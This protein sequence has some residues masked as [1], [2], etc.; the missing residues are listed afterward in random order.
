MVP[1]WFW[2]SFTSLPCVFCTLGQGNVKA[3]EAADAMLDA[4]IGVLSQNT[5]AALHT[6]RFVLFQ[7]SMLKD[8]YSSM[9]QREAAGTKP[10]SWIGSTMSKIRGKNLAENNPQVRI[11][12][13][14]FRSSCYSSLSFSCSFTVWQCREATRRKVYHQ[15]RGGE[16]CLLSHLWQIPGWCGLC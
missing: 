6:V 8:F 13:W 12:S 15:N 14:R 7:P 2:W 5:S 1:C 9:Q 3:K 11:S 16:T 10:A 4:V